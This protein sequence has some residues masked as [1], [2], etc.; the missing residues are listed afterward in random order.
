M[1]YSVIIPFRGTTSLL[2]TA[3]SSIPDRDDIQIIV[4]DNNPTAVDVSFLPAPIHSSILLLRSNPEKG[5][6]HARNVGL[7]NADG[8]YLLFLDADDYFT[9]DA[10]IYFDKFIDSG[11]DIVYF[12]ALSI[13]ID[14]DEA[15]TR[16]I[17]INKLIKDAISSGN[18]DGLRYKFCNPV[19]KMILR[20]LV[21]E[22]KVRFQEVPAAN[23]QMFSVWTGHYAR[24]I[25]AVDSVVYMITE[26]R[27]NSSL[28]KLKDLKNQESRFKVD[29]CYNTFLKSIGR[30]DLMC[31][32]SSEI[33]VSFFKFGPSVGWS[34]IKYAWNNR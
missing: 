24:N 30:K 28:T 8:K 16:H 2:C 23:D 12:N 29:V 32:I 15:S 21:E 7:D 11:Y 20:S 1:N 33:I 13:K 3:L 10:F 19:S 9:E 14:S 34:W 31:R 17:M 22:F 5:A 6:G 18:D 26:G 25:K 4:V 27:K